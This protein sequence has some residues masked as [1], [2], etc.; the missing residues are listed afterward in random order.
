MTGEA[1]WLSL[2]VVLLAALPVVYF[3]IRSRRE[4]R[5]YLVEQGSVRCRTRG[6][7]IVRCMVRDAKTG[8]PIEIR[9]CSAVPGDVC[10]D[11]TCL[12]PLFA[13]PPPDAGRARGNR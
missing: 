2:A 8:Q 12:P 10:H 4:D 9:T 13:A 7:Q 5:K 11:K 1:H 6:D 3:W